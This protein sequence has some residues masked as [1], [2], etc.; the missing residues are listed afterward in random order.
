MGVSASGREAAKGPSVRREDGQNKI[1]TQGDDGSACLRGAAL[2]K[3][4]SLVPISLSRQVHLPPTPLLPLERVSQTE[5]ADAADTI[6]RNCL[7]YT[8]DA[9]DD[10]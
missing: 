3:S 5:L 8:S 9:A 4:R 1:S 10:M 7:L 6:G 2:T